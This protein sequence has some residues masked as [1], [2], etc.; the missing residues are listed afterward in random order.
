MEACTIYIQS[1]NQRKYR[2]FFS[3]FQLKEKPSNL[4]YMISSQNTGILFYVPIKGTLVINF[5]SFLRWLWNMVHMEW[6]R[7]III[8]VC[9]YQIKF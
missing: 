6:S 1:D 2:I 5:K 4:F 9:L 8:D 3:S 7:E